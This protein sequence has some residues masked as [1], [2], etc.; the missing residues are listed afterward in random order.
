LTS[1]AFQ[2][3]VAGADLSGSVIT[4]TASN[5]THDPY[6]VIPDFFYETTKFVAD[7]I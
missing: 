5:E 7:T 4:L 2:T 3:G 6:F 1:K